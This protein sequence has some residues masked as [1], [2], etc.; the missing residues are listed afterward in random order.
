[1]KYQTRRCCPPSYTRAQSSHSGRNQTNGSIKPTYEGI[2]ML[3]IHCVQTQNSC[4]C[5]RT[6]KTRMCSVSA[7]QL[8]LS[9]HR[10]SY[11]APYCRLGLQVM[12]TFWHVTAG[13]NNTIYDGYIPFSCCSFRGLDCAFWLTVTLSGLLGQPS[14]ISI[15]N[16]CAFPVT[17][18]QNVCYE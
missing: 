9:S 6:A 3:D 10:G 15:G 7:K 1:M 18:S 2:C 5:W 13:V 17:M 11:T 8:L 12:K 14:L 16:T 4:K